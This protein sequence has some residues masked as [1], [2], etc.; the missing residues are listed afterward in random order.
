MFFGRRSTQAEYL[1]TPGRSPA[2]IAAD[3][4]EL[5]RVNRLFK[6]SHPFQ[7]V[8]TRRLGRS[9]CRELKLLDIEERIRPVDAANLQISN[10]PAT[11]AVLRPRIIRLEIVI[12]GRVCACSAVEHIVAGIAAQMIIGLVADKAV[13]ARTT[14]CVFNQ[15]RR[16]ALEHERVRDISSRVMAV[17]QIGK[18]RRG[19][20]RPRA[21]IQINLQV[22]RI[23]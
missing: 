1:D 3:Y 17:A 6:F 7:W 15:R 16:I 5:G 22:R 20:R 14:D 12:D 9:R 13:A 10:E 11:V 4:R 18:L 19:R 21:G 8:L 2:E 23:V